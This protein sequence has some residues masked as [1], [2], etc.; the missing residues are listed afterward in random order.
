MTMIR[1]RWEILQIYKDGDIEVKIID[2][3]NGGSKTTFKTTQECVAAANVQDKKEL[4]KGLAFD[5][6]S[7]EY[8]QIEIVSREGIEKIELSRELKKLPEEVHN[9]LHRMIRNCTDAH[10]IVEVLDSKLFEELVLEYP[11]F[12]TYKKVTLDTL[13]EEL[14]LPKKTYKDII[15]KVANEVAKY[16][17]PTKLEIQATF[18]HFFEHPRMKM[19]KEA[20]P[21]LSILERVLE[22]MFDP[23]NKTLRN[24]YNL[25]NE[26][27]Q[28]KENITSKSNNEAPKAE[29][30]PN[31]AAETK[32]VKQEEEQPISSVTMKFGNKEVKID[33]SAA[34][35]EVT[36][37]DLSFLD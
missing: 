8:E 21:S 27:A 5:V 31:T 7:K 10:D 4:R 18:K 6:T 20:Y 14:K 33:T 11:I 15:D 29:S 1:E 12:E 17:S 36:D 24:P 22:E 13:S 19:I 37:E 34:K 3:L 30:A 26:L 9:R 35:D 32:E 25:E 28:K 2:I 23:N 16:D